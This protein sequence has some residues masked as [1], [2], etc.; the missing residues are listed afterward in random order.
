MSSAVTIIAVLITFIGIIYVYVKYAFSYWQRKGI[1]YIEPK[2]PFGNL[3]DSLTQRSSLPDEFRKYYESTNEPVIGLY[4]IFRP[5]LLV[6]DPEIIRDILIRSFPHFNKNGFHGNEDVDPM[7]GNLLLQSGDKWK[8]WRTKLSPSFTSVR[9]KGMF[10]AIVYAGD[11]LQN[12]LAEYADCNKTI[13]MR[14]IFAR[15][16]MNAIASVAFGINIDCIKNPDEEFRKYGR[17][18]FEPTFKNSLRITMSTMLP[19]LLRLLRIRYTDKDVGDFMIETCR[20]NLEHREKNNL[21]RKDFFQLLIQLRN[22]GKVQEDNNWSAES[23]NLSNSLTLNEI[24][25]QAFLFFIAGYESSSTT[26]SFSMYEL[27]RNPEIQQKTYEEIVTVLEK[28]NGK[29]THDSVNEMKYLDKIIDGK[30]L[31]VVRANVCLIFIIVT[32]TLRMHPAFGMLTR[33]CTIEYNLPKSNVVIEKD[34]S[35]VMSIAG[36]QYDQKYFKQPNQF[37][38]E[39]FDDKNIADKTFVDMPFLTFGAGPRKCLGIR[40]GKLQTKLGL[41]L[42]LKKFRFELGEE[43]KGKA[44]V[45]NPKGA[46]KCTING[47]NLK[48]FSR[49]KF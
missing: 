21:T 29:L 3:T 24:S 48:V 28:H 4:S 16:A 31:V 27:A 46:A 18:F 49:S 47:I 9:L 30:I 39:R 40:L 41:I 17:R 14:E 8:H 37:I 2:F 33:V 23:G 34:T 6:R 11:S 38:P 10:D 32:E 12:F 5:T 20:Q 1:P 26:M 36:L 15:F 43:H 19:K 22:T 42:S 13:E 44:L 25:A 35:I 45:I 7:A